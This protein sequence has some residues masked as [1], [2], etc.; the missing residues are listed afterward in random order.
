MALVQFYEDDCEGRLFGEEFIITLSHPKGN[1]RRDEVTTILRK[2]G[3]KLNKKW[4]K[5]EWGWEAKFYQIAKR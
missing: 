5:A 2:F 1:L 3:F 4:T